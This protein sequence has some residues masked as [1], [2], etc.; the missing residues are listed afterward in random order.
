MQLIVIDELT[1]K[2]PDETKAEIDLP[3]KLVAGFRDLAVHEY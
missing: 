3:W 1:K 2:L